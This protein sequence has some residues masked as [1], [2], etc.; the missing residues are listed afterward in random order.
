MNTKLILKKFLQNLRMEKKSLLI[1]LSILAVAF[2]SV[3][4]VVALLTNLSHTIT[5]AQ[6]HFQ[7]TVYLEDSAEKEK[8]DALIKAIDNFPEVR[9][10]RYISKETFRKS[11]LSGNRAGLEG[12]SSLGNDVFPATLQVKLSPEFMEHS[13]ATSIVERLGKVDIV[14]EV[15]YH[16]SRLKNLSGFL[17]VV[18]VGIIIFA[19]LI[20]ASSLLAMSNMIQL[21]FSKRSRAIKLMRLCGATTSFIEIPVL[22]EGF[23]IGLMGSIISIAVTW[24]ALFALESKIVAC[25]EGFVSFDICFIPVPVIA[26]LIATC[27]LTGMSGAYLA[28]RKILRV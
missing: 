9:Q 12:V 3:T 19:V 20:L 6:E 15:G 7:L 5:G 25:L 27:A 10:V 22:M 18:W 28:S 26:A 24:A 2:L 21:S 1:N 17:K 13:S 8:T 23:F 14:E 4:A 16:E 11:F